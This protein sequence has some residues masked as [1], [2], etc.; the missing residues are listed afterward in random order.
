M[1]ILIHSRTGG[2]FDWRKKL[3]DLNRLPSIGEY[4]AATMK[5]GGSGEWHEVRLVVHVADKSNWEAEVF[6]NRIG[7]EQAKKLGWT[8]TMPS[9]EPSA[10]PVMLTLDQAA[11]ACGTSRFTV[12]RL[13]AA[14]RLQ[15]KASNLCIF[16][17]IRLRAVPLPRK[18]SFRTGF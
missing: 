12:Q 14:G 8:A 17:R 9:N 2:E 5:D 6:C 3:V 1:R 11:K 4:I 18:R 13:I 10:M 15:A 7:P 16:G